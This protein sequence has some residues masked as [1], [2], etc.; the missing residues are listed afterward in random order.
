MKVE[1]IQSGNE[2]GEKTFAVTFDCPC[3]VQKWKNMAWFRMG[4]GYGGDELAEVLDILFP[5]ISPRR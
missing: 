1:I 2:I 4:Q 5:D 3:E